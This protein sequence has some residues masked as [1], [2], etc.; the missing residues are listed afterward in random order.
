MYTPLQLATRYFNYYLT[1]S[2]G[3]GHGVH[4][5]FVYQL[6]REVLM[7][8]SP[9]EAAGAIE[10]RRK[11]LLS[12][13][14]V[15]EVTDFGAGSGHLKTKQRKVKDIAA[16]SLKPA[17]YA[18]LLHRLAR[19]YHHTQILELGT[20][21][22]ITTAYLAATS[23]NYHVITCEGA[24]EIAAIAREGFEQLG[25]SNIQIETGSFDETLPLILKQLPAPE[26]VFIDG[27]H[28]K[29]PTL[30]YFHQILEVLPQHGLMVFDDIHWSAE[31]ESAW[32]TIQRH[33][34]VTL[35]VDLFFIGLVWINPDFRQPAHYVIRF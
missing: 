5:P 25:L 27:N 35:S 29:M 19:Y 20:S 15:L 34:A 23:P 7:D 12:D 3:R 9:I 30:Q 22:G 13:Q 6:V 24:P 32:Q 31:M 4:S 10:A 8:R 21:L 26:L 28:R 2:N 17:K 33:P 16:T 1:A 11:Q 18:R 14:R